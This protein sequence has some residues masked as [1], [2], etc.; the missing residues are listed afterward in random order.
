MLSDG[1]LLLQIIS[2]IDGHNKNVVEIEYMDCN[3]INGKI[4][5]EFEGNLIWTTL[6]VFRTEDFAF[7]SIR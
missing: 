6:D 2:I 5:I 3:K 7:I 1:V 4:G